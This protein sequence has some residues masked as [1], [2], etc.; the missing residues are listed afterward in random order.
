[1]NQLF[2]PCIM[3]TIIICCTIIIIA[4]VILSGYRI[5]RQKE[6]SSEGYIF[7]SSILAVLAIAI[8]SYAFY[9]NRTVLD[10]ISLASA[11]I[12]IILA[13]ITIIY[14]FYTNGRSVGQAEK[15]QEA[16]EKVQNAT[17]SYSE[18]ADSLQENIHEILKTLLEV[19]EYA[20]ETNTKFNN[21]SSISPSAYEMSAIGGVDIHI[22][23]DKLATAYINAGSFIGNLGLLACVYSE[24]KDN[25]FS[26]SIF[27]FYDSDTFKYGYICGY[28]I[29]SSALGVINAR[30]DGDTIYVTKVM[31]N[32]QNKL[33]HMI[34]EYIDKKENAEIKEINMK[35]YN[36]IKEAFNIQ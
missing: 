3:Q 4:L 6:F 30:V 21:L 20:K 27:K 12:S 34:K 29:A 35:L 1:M 28:I 25:K 9:G 10:F 24:K 14:S 8:F 32:L 31:D 36:D 26:L 7:I 33:E 18:S 13:I 5:S 19:R 16:A 23:V 11:L 15:L 22:D 2:T 17:N